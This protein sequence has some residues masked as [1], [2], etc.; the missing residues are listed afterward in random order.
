MKDQKED[1]DIV[2]K[3]EGYNRKIVFD[4]LEKYGINESIRKKLSKKYRPIVNSALKE[5]GVLEILEKTEPSVNLAISR[6]LQKLCVANFPFFNIPMLNQKTKE[7]VTTIY[8]KEFKLLLLES[9]LFDFEEVFCNMIEFPCT[10]NVQICKFSTTDI[11]LVK[12]FA[13]S[14]SFISL[15]KLFHRRI[16]HPNE[17]TNQFLEIDSDVQLNANKMNQIKKSQNWGNIYVT[18]SES[19][20]IFGP[21]IKS[22]IRSNYKK[23]KKSSTFA[24]ARFVDWIEKITHKNFLF[25]IE[26]ASIAKTKGDLLQNS[27]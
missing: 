22:D 3:Y 4:S 23:K 24:I 26:S 21:Y 19:I 10:G 7:I 17:V 5:K 13:G 20:M 1:F 9:K 2:G 6:S 8:L 27:Q 25:T 16:V 18:C 11:E 15:D 12:K 14:Y